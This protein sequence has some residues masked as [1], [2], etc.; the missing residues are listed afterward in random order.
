MSRTFFVWAATLDEEPVPAGDSGWRATLK[1]RLAFAL[2]VAGLR[3]S[4]VIDYMAASALRR[5]VP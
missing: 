3:S 4:G 1:H 5:Q 2:Q